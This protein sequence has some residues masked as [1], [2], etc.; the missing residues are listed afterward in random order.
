MAGPTDGAA[1]VAVRGLVKRFG[2]H[3]A[4]TG[5]TFTVQPGRVTGFVGPN[6]G[7]KSTT[8]RAIVGPDRPTVGWPP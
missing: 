2:K 1:V 8:I 6:G 5:L 7:G 3:T 4:V